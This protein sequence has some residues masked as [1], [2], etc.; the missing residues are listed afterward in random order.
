[1]NE[2]IRMPKLLQEGC[3]LQQ[4]ERTRIWGWYEKNSAV[5]LSFQ[6]EEKQAVTD[7]DGYFE[8]ELPCRMTGGPF[9]LKIQS[10]DEKDC[11]QAQ[12]YVGDVFV[13]AGQSNMELP[14]A[15]VREMFPQE[16]GCGQVR[17]YKVEEC[18]EFERPLTEHINAGW[19]VCIG[20]DLEEASAFGYFFGK[21]IAQHRQVPVGIIQLSK[22]GSPAE[23]WTSVEGLLGYPDHLKVLHRF[24]S[25]EFRERLLASQEE[26]ERAWHD[27]LR[28]IEQETADEPWRQL[29]AP[30]YFAEQGLPDF[31]GLLYLK[32]TFYVPGRLAGKEA[33]LKLGTLTDSD[34]T[35]VN[36][37]LVGKT[38][39][40]FPPRIYPIP[41]EVLKE[42]ENEIWIRL[43]C[44]DGK[45]RITP[46]KPL[47]VCFAAGENISL[48]GTWRCQ[49][50]AVYKQAPVL[51]FLT[52]QPASLYQGM[53]APCLNMTV[54]GVVWYQGES[55]EWQA[56]AYGP[57][58]KT[59]IQD[60]RSHWRQEKLP[61]V[62][63]QLPACGVDIRGGGAWALIREAQERALEL[64]DTAMTVNLDLGE[65]YDL[66]PLNKKSAA[67]RAY[68][69]ARYLFYGEDLIWQGPKLV[70]AEKTKDGVQLFYDTKD[71][72]P[73][74]LVCGK[75][76]CEYEAA[77]ADGVFYPMEAE[78]EADRVKLVPAAGTPLWA[79]QIQK[80]RYAWSDAPLH[81]LIGNQQGLPAAPFLI[82]MN[83]KSRTGGMA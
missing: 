53:V 58:L 2:G 52:R 80:V 12:A 20:K 49:V 13:C 21:E 63:V 44:R 23:A 46:K 17:C 11:F 62:I 48:R 40:C 75:K 65:Y 32:K 29:E 5:C 16:T 64:A 43:E 38:D 10:C 69:A 67:Y 9:S 51:Q 39:Y 28:R 24:Q 56:S 47:D 1:M 68:L 4:G 25:K 8:A 45:G 41:E 36:G 76:L 61:F 70:K 7:A 50:R 71:G 31:C 78:L 54:R 22:G 37:V 18:P 74:K 55:N 33:V 83:E 19:K 77:G 81:G 30:G 57:L 14:I 79:A 73:L 72:K 42:G 59:M 66:H 82:D 26:K 34:E 15:R 3:V 27:A 60:W 35:Y 6:G